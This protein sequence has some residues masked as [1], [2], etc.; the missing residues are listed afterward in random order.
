MERPH[1]GVVLDREHELAVEQ[2]LDAPAGATA[3]DR[4]R[5]LGARQGRQR[6]RARGAVALKPLPLLEGDDSDLRGRPGLAVDVGG[7]EVAERGE[8][9]LHAARRLVGG[10][11]GIRLRLGR[12][13]VRRAKASG[14]SGTVALMPGKRPSGTPPPTRILAVLMP[15]TDGRRLHDLGEASERAG[16]VVALDEG[17][18]EI[19]GGDVARD[20]GRADRGVR[21][22]VRAEAALRLRCRRAGDERSS[23]SCT[24]EPGRLTVTICSPCRNAT[25]TVGAAPAGPTRPRAR[26]AMRSASRL[27]CTARDSTLG[28]PAAR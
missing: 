18:V 24:V 14:V 5:A 22:E 13:D 2:H 17:L 9:L 15:G 27:A 11:A 28:C 7:Q 16:R 8:L 25:L 4:R 23:A 26:T 6:L 21:R 3:R 10:L 19:D 12:R 1:D 20:R